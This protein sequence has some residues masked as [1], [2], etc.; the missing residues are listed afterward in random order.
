MIWLWNVN[1]QDEYKESWIVSQCVWIQQRKQCTSARAFS[2]CNW[3]HAQLHLTSVMAKWIVSVIVLPVPC[4]WPW[5]LYFRFTESTHRRYG[6][7]SSLKSS[8]DD[9]EY[10][11][12]QYE[13]GFC[14]QC[15]R[16]DH[17]RLIQMTRLKMV[18]VECTSAIIWPMPL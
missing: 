15:Q 6:R 5:T 14:R 18:S 8:A 17:K 16:S 10:E 1:F 7:M 4:P 9:L 13:G 2:H 12:V 3:W 11:Q